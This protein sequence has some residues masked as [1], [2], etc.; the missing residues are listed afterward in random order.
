MLDRFLVSTV[1]GAD[2]WIRRHKVAAWAI[3]GVMLASCLYVRW[4]SGV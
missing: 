1:N 2:R 3:W 4:Q